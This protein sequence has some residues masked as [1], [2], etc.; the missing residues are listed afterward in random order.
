MD[1]LRL[2]TRDPQTQGNEEAEQDVESLKNK[3]KEADDL[4]SR[5]LD[6]ETERRYTKKTA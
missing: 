4:Q 5:L 3:L 6:G 1:G 2:E